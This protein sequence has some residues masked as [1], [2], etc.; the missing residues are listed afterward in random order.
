[1][2]MEWGAE[3]VG[4]HGE[5]FHPADLP[6]YAPFVGEEPVGLLSYHLTGNECEIVFINSWQKGLGA[7]NTIIEA[8][9]QTAGQTGCK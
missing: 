1:M 5:I 8:A 2:I 9:R 7:G 3:I 6:G 4:N